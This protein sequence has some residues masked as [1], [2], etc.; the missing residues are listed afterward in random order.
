MDTLNQ[1]GNKLTGEVDKN[2]ANYW[3][4][5]Y[6]LRYIMERDWSKIGKDLKG[7]NKYLLW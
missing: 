5:N 3:K 4:E 1:F 2:V 6:D 7:K